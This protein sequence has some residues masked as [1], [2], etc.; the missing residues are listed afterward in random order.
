LDTLY[1]LTATERYYY[2]VDADLAAGT[3]DSQIVGAVAAKARQNTSERLLVRLTAATAEGG[4]RIVDQP[5][6]IRHDEA[7]QF[8]LTEQV[9]F[10]RYRETLR[11]DTA[12]LV[13]QYRLVD[14]ALRIVGVGSEGPRCWIL[15]LQGPSG[16]P[17]FL[18]AKEAGHSVLETYGKI[19]GVR[20]SIVE[21]LSSRGQGYRVVGAQRILQSQSDPFLGWLAEVPG[22]DGVTRDFYVRQFRDMK[23]SFNL[24][25]FTPGQNARYA[26]ACGRLLAR[27]HSQGPGSAHICG[28]LGT[29]DAFDQ[30]ISRWARQYA[31]QAERD[32]QALALAVR[33]GR[34]P[35]ESGV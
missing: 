17:L 22:P 34:L 7:D 30:A 24:A 6:I 13:H 12:V 5:P 19:T 29:S 2:Q 20:R 28:Y 8:G 33:S 10:L 26:R 31:D 3:K 32:H 15:L 35:A 18:Q 23:G 16:E 9:Y 25:Q 14:Y 11:V 27:A 21:T 1:Q 4:I